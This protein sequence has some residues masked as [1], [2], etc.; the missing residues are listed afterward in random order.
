[1]EDTKIQWH[2]GFVAAMSLEFKSDRESL[3]FQKE[4]NLNTKPLEV[5]LLVIKKEASARIENE[6]GGFFRGHNIMEYKSPEDVLNI[7]VLYKAIAYAALYKS[8]GKSVDEREADDITV[9]LVRE[10][11]PKGLFE[12][13][14]KQGNPLSQ[15]YK[16]IYYVGGHCLFPIQIVVTKELD[17]EAHA[18]L[19]ALSRK[20]EEE[21]AKRLLEKI[22]GLTEKED[23]DMADSVLRVM[24]EANGQIVEKWKGDA[25]MFEAL[26][27]IMEPQIQMREKKVW[28][29]GIE[30]GRKEG[31]EE[32]RR[33][34]MEEGRKEGIQVIAGTLRELGQRDEYIRKVIMKKY[35]IPEEKAE[36]YLGIM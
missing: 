27:E 9:T 33:E 14:E 2:P 1:M 16:G 24:L 30:K 15:P 20:V 3:I 36:E 32:G 8:Y 34:G 19:K 5:D 29:E 12:H 10:G 26:M 31:M 18:W 21:A 6:I 17:G 23:K 25:D 22:K 13:L 11:K 28:E 7:D 4:H 35:G